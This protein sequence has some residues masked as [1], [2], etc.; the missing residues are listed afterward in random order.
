MRQSRD[1]KKPKIP[2]FERETK[3]KKRQRLENEKGTMV[4]ATVPWNLRPV[5]EGYN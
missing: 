1:L 5:V 3:K 2:K 4:T